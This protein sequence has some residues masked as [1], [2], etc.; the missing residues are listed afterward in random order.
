M[1]G[2][3]VVEVDLPVPGVCGGCCGLVEGRSSREVEWGPPHN[4]TSTENILKIFNIYQ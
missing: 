2:V 3:C 1:P 4:L